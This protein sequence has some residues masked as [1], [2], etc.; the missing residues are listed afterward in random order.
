M[1]LI[2]AVDDDWAI[3]KRNGLLY[4]LPEDLKYFKDKTLNKVVIMGD[5]TIRSLPGGK[6][7]PKRTTV[8]MS[9]EPDFQPEGIKVCHSVGEL[10]DELKKYVDEDVYVCGGAGIYK[11]L[12][13][14]CKTA[15]ITKIHASSPDAE[16]FFPD[17]D[18]LDNWHLTQSTDIQDNGTYKYQFCTYTNDNPRTI[19]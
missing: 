13:P 5:N 9:L 8:A 14:Y 16:V 4:H 2:V 6:P 19:R 1:N 10:G 15:Y 11:L 3:G 17:L 7:L 18:K 12:L